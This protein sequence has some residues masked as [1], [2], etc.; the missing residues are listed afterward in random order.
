MSDYDVA[1]I[2]EQIELQLIA[3]M[4][5]NLRGHEL[6]ENIEG[7]KWE[8][9]QSKKLRELR[10]FRKQNKAIFNANRQQLDIATRLDI[11]KQFLEGGRKVDKGVKEAI[12]KGYMT[13]YSPT[14]AFFNGQN[15]KLESLIKSINADMAQA[16]TA[17]LRK[18]DDVYRGTLYK[19]QM[20]SAAGASTVSQAVDMATK[21]FLAKGIACITYSDGRNVG[22]DTWAR[23]A[24]RTAN[25]RA[26]LMG[27]GERRKEWGESLV[28]VSQYLQCSP[29][30]Q[31]W[32]GK[33]YIDDVWS[34]G[35]PEDGPYPL[36]SLAIS[37]GLY[38]PN[39]RHTQSTW[40]EGINTVPEPMSAEVT[41][42]EYEKARR[43]A[44]INQNIR[45]YQRLKEGS[46]DQANID[47]YKAKEKAWKIRL[48]NM[49]NNKKT[50]WPQIGKVITKE[51][52][53][54][55]R[56]YAES[57]GIKLSQFKKFDGDT[58]LIRELIDDMGSIS[59][60]Y[61]KVKDL[62]LSLSQ[63]MY[64]DDFAET[65]GH[66]ITINANAF[67]SKESLISEYNKL[68]SDGW[69]TSGTSYR[70]I[71]KHE[72]GHVIDNTYRFNSN[73]IA[74]EILQTDTKLDLYKR[75]PIE[76]SEYAAGFDDGG[77]II[78]EVFAEV[79]DSKNPRTFALKFKEYIDNIILK[80]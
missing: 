48:K 14:E 47:K 45:K 49:S 72:M 79:Y 66:I 67:R 51:Q 26:F 4:K 8:Q 9:W 50:R 18:M 27:E 63:F 23:M 1:N 25:K 69:F 7:F 19:S 56:E 2:F 54:E 42:E 30:C 43:E 36:L 22:I 76:L 20:F 35:K 38:H 71:I 39:C 77:E 24:I 58:Q 10:K 61:P 29:I 6:E 53:K 41:R 78:S 59:N 40:F 32:Q 3:S 64:D 80:G 37:G 13:K 68:V 34:G 12:R 21:D 11:I 28:L 55:M 60:S 33:V 44:Y 74:K 75:L 46:T 57:K 17:C 16:E 73:N 62:T 31:P 65:M 52:Y 70:A 5:R 15:K